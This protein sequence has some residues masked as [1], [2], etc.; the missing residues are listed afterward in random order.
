M[1]IQNWSLATILLFTQIISVNS[2]ADDQTKNITCILNTRG[3]SET[4]DKP[5]VELAS[6]TKNVD[7]SKNSTQIKGG[8]FN[9]VYFEVNF[10]RPGLLNDKTRK[11]E[12]QEYVMVTT[13]IIDK[14]NGHMNVS[15]IKF[16]VKAPIL[17][18]SS[19]LTGYQSPG[20]VWVECQ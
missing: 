13:R 20:D 15:K 14:D 11:V 8:D 6:V 1:K 3:T 19:W 4:V 12:L 18:F 9:H 7:I 17:A 16:D 5:T 10:L 2:F